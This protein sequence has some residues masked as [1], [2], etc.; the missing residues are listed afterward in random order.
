MGAA[1]TNG[2]EHYASGNWLVKEGS[3]REFVARWR[4]WLTASTRD[5]PGFGS[6]RLLQDRSD[7]RHFVSVSEWADPDS[8]DAWKSSPAFAE[9]LASCRFLCED[10]Q[11]GDFS[12]V[13]A[14]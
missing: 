13:V 3:E 4:D 7:P 10:F 8:R 2:G 6:A 5:V 12:K 14:V 11:G 9:G 1:R